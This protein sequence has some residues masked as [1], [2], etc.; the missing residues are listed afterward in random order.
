MNGW[1]LAGLIISLFLF[2]Y[3]SYVICNPDKF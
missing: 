3:L 1:Y 2:V